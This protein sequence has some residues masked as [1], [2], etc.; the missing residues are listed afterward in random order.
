MADPE[1]IFTKIT[2]VRKIFV[3][4]LCTKFHKNAVKGAVGDTSHRLTDG[5][6]GVLST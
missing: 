2:H 3:K 6:T 4:K 1:R 5:R